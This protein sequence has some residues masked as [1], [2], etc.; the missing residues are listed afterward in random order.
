MWSPRIAEA[1]TGALWLGLVACDET[2]V[3]G[4]VVRRLRSEPAR[5]GHRR[6]GI[7]NPFGRRPQ[8]GVG[9]P[10]GVKTRGNARRAKGPYV[11][12]VSRTEGIAA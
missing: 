9:R 7:H 3:S 12:C 10:I 8:S 4:R 5:R 6:R 11:S 1:E 2:G